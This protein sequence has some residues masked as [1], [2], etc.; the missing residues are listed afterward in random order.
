MGLVE[1]WG[2]NPLGWFVASLIEAI[3]NLFYALFHPGQWLAWLPYINKPLDDVEVKLSL[4][5]FVY[6]GASVEFFFVMLVI[7][8][9]AT[10]IGLWRNSI[11]WGYVRVLEG[12]GNA[13]GRL[14]AWAGLLMVLQQILIIFLQRVFSVSEIAMG[15]GISFSRDVSWWSEELKLYNAMIVCM[16]VAY[17]FIQGSHVRVDLVYSVVKFR[18]KRVIDMFGSLFFMLPLAVLVWLYG[19]FFL[20]GSLIVRRASVTDSLERLVDPN[21]GV[22][23]NILTTTTNPSGFDAYFLFKILLL[24]FAALVVLQAIA[25]FYRSLLEFKEGEASEGKYL[26]RDSLGDE[27]AELV[28]KIH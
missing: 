14:F 19:W 27:T 21:R 20:W 3:Y 24:A 28:A 12:I 15:F 13:L 11:M 23:W 16:C 9:V 8:L 26:D 7:F 4:M 2:G 22:R 1:A 10:G 5:R 6:Y 25:F 17:T 18:T